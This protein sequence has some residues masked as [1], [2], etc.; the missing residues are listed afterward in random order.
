MHKRLLARSSFMLAAAT[1]LLLGASIARAQD[2][3]VP[4]KR[5]RSP[6]TVRG[7]IGGEGHDSYVIRARRGQRMTVSISWRKDG[8]NQAGFSIS[9]SPNFFSAEPVSFGQE[10]NEGKNWT[11]RIP[12]AG[13][14][15]I[16][17]TAHPVA[18]YVLRVRLK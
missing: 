2:D 9:R 6:A 17:V 8:D 18:D 3:L 7:T 15:Y 16:Y 1:L 10:S 12:R 11:G 5:L 4:K 14:Y 13:N